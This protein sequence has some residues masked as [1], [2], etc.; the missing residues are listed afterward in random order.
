MKTL[1]KSRTRSSSK[2]KNSLFLFLNPQTNVQATRVRSLCYLMLVLVIVNTFPMIYILMSDPSQWLNTRP[3]RVS[4]F[5]IHITTQPK[6]TEATTTSI[7]RLVPKPEGEKLIL[8]LDF[9]NYYQVDERAGRFGLSQCND[10]NPFPQPI[11][12]ELT[13]D[14]NRFNQS[15]AVVFYSHGKNNMEDFKFT[16][17]KHLGQTWTFFAAESPEYSSN[18]V[19][20]SSE[21]HNKFNSSMTYRTD[22]EF[23][24]GY[25]RPE[26]KKTPMDAQQ[27][28]QQETE[29]RWAFR[30]KTRMAA[31]FVSHCS[32][33]SNR[34]KYIRQL[35][36]FM[37]VDVF[38][39]CGHLKCVDRARC[40]E[41]LAREYKFYLAFENSLC[42]DYVTEKLLRAMNTMRVV[43]VV[44]GGADYSRL[45]PV[46]SVIDAGQFFS[47]YE[48]AHH[49]NS[50]AED[51]DEWVRMFQWTWN[52]KMVGSQL[53]LC[54]YCYHLYKRNRPG[55][56]HAN[57][58]DWWTSGA[59][60]KP[61]DL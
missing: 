26:R 60:N 61:I 55:H 53:P 18:L 58:H 48:L 44:R 15:D 43:P 10:K 36:K 35:K 14:Y 2:T 31:I 41:L 51:E 9:P 59:C 3:R 46:N 37:D 1:I 29:L 13:T 47:A 45:F 57:I 19:F 30:N 39:R 34:G 23:W 8:F 54:Q 11:K 6:A 4:P 52:W 27:K 33:S 20:S 5:K 49:L 50:L 16:P 7:P 12:C 22:S 28:K 42:V 32:T 40:D 25:V 38:G 21:F 56:V 24:H 17:K